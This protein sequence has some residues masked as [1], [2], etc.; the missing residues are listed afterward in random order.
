MV[1]IAYLWGQWTGYMAATVKAIREA[2]RCEVKVLLP[3]P[4][5]DRESNRRPFNIQQI[6]ENET[7]L[8]FSEQLTD[9][10]VNKFVDL[11]APDIVICSGWNH[12]AFMRLLRRSKGR[13]VRVLS[14]D[15]QWIW[16]PK[17]VGGILVSPWMLKPCFDAVFASGPRQRRFARSL[18][19]R[20]STIYEGY[21]SCDVSLFAQAA[22]RS[23]FEDKF[24][25]AGRL[26]DDKSINE[27]LAGYRLYRERTAR[28]WSLE[29]IGNGP[30]GAAATGERGV[31]VTGF[32][33]PAELAQAFSG[34][35]CFILPSKFEPWGVVLHEA[36][37]AGLPLIGSQQCGS[38]D[39]FLRHGW[40]GLLLDRADPRSISDAM[41]EIASF[42][43]DKRAAFGRRSEALAATL[44]PRIW[45]ETF[46]HAYDNARADGAGH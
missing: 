43:A 27:L 1:K 18:G 6:G 46:W 35:G 24:V 21:L 12:R 45:A 29:L 20:T 38:A 11:A 31:T 44:T 2:R 30:L 17:Q 23:H 7:E 8:T 13:F 15:N 32:K 41:S 5:I 9:E 26:V 34:A 14:M 19:F 39:L 25:F 22:R 42:S 40:N 16:R 36:A 3:A 37:S 28:P 10:V 33:Q 4:T